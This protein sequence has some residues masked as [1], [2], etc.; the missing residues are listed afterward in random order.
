MKMTTFTVHLNHSGLTL[1]SLSTFAQEE[2]SPLSPPSHGESDQL[3]HFKSLSL[4]KKVKVKIS[5]I[6]MVVSILNTEGRKTKQQ[7]KNVTLKFT[8]CMM[9]ITFSSLATQLW[10]EK[11]VLENSSFYL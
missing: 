9:K 5:M 8:K 6:N 1:S 3:G 10:R 11:K 4:K 7:Q 2:G